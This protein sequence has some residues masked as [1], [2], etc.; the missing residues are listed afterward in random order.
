MARLNCLPFSL[1][2][3]MTQ[4]VF[5]LQF[6]SKLLR[7]R[8]PLLSRDCSLYMSRLAILLSVLSHFHKFIGAR[9]CSS[10]RRL[11]LSLMICKKLFS[12]AKQYYYNHVVCDVLTTTL[13]TFSLMAYYFHRKHDFLLS[14]SNSLSF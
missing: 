7:Y 12:F 2:H 4:C 13:V 1:E 11:C 8:Y 6:P 3:S 5:E 9:F 14:A 10:K